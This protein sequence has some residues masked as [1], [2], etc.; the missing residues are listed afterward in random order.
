[1][2]AGIEEVQEGAPFLKDGGLVLLLGQLVVDILELDC[3]GVVPIRDTADTVREHSLK[4]NRLLRCPGNAV[5]P[6]GFLYHCFQ[7]LLLFPRQ[8]FRGNRS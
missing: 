8:L 1:M 2:D 6:L 5:V 7:F 3:L 4:R